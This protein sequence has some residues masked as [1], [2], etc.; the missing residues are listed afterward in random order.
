MWRWLWLCVR[1]CCG[2]WL[3]SAAAQPRPAGL[4]E[5]RTAQARITVDGQTTQGPVRLPYIWD[6]RQPGHAGTAQFDM[7]FALA[8]PSDTP[9]GVYFLRLGNTYEVWLNGGL[10]QRRGDLQGLDDADY[11]KVPRYI[12][13]PA[14]LLQK[15]N[16]LRVLVHAHVGRRGGMAAVVVGPENAVMARYQQEAERVDLGFRL[17]AFW[18]LFMVIMASLLWWTQTEPSATRPGAVERDRLYL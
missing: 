3:G 13:I 4:L 18:G 12:S 14:A 1:L 17:L 6:R 11:A 8:G 2:L 5:L 10:L 16:L 15:D 9:Y 7:V